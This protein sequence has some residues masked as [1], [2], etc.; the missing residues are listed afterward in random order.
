MTYPG[1]FRYSVPVKIEKDSVRQYYVRL[2][3]GEFGNPYLVLKLYG[4][5]RFEELTNLDWRNFWQGIFHGILW[6][7]IIYNIFF[8]FIGRD[9]TYFYYA[10]YMIAISLYFLNIFGFLNKYVFFHACLQLL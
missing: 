2:E 1:A 9:R 7:M 3:N 5:D 6:V 8:A 10:L 4:E